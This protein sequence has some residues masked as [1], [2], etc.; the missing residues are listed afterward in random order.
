MPSGSPNPQVGKHRAFSRGIKCFIWLLCCQRQVL[1]LV[2]LLCLLGLGGSFLFSSWA[3]V[4]RMYRRHVDHVLDIARTCAVLDRRYER[5]NPQVCPRP[6]RQ[7]LLALAIFSRS[8]R[9][10]AAVYLPNGCIFCGGES[11]SV[12]C[13]LFGGRISDHTASVVIPIAPFSQGRTRVLATVC[14]V[15]RS[16]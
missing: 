10:A 4:V 3:A 12:P 13:V 2:L 15:H 14:R 8:C 6:V 1:L 9:I 16:P 11:A 5:T 7:V